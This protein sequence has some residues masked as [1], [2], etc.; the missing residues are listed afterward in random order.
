MPV[1]PSTCPGGPAC[2]PPDGATEYEKSCPL[3]RS[4]TTVLAL[5]VQS[6]RA[7]HAVSDCVDTWSASDVTRGLA[8]LPLTCSVPCSTYPS[9]R[10]RWDTAAVSLPMPLRSVPSIF[11]S[12]SVTVPAANEVGQNASR[13]D[14][15][16]AKNHSR[17]LTIGPPTWPSASQRESIWTGRKLTCSCGVSEPR[18]LLVHD[19]CVVQ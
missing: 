17:C 3:W 15:P 4:S 1:T 12:A 6:S 13:Y 18:L 8:L 2:R 11:G 10:T 9:I 7:F 16:P 14:S 5:A 19:G